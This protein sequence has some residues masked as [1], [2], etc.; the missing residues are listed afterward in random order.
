MAYN[1]R[2]K[3][4]E[5]RRITEIYKEVKQPDIPDTFIVSNI[6]PKHGIFIS[7]R[8]W[9]YIKGM[10]PSEL[11]YDEEKQEDPDQLKMF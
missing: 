4:R 7:Y 6:F 9:V 11:H 1:P 10:K 8:K 5:F 2:N 3:L